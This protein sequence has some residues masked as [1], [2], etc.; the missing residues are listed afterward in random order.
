MTYFIQEIQTLKHKFEKK[1]LDKAQVFF[2]LLKYTFTKRP[3]QT[4]I[5]KWST[6]NYILNKVYNFNMQRYPSCYY[7]TTTGS[8]TVDGE[9]YETEHTERLLKK[10]GTKFLFQVC[11][12][13]TIS[14]V[15]YTDCSYIYKDANFIS[16]CQILDDD[17][18]EYFI[19][20]IQQQSHV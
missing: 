2:N 11:D 5:Q 7:S 3:I 15:E 18:L 14:E 17:T 10:V 6:Y 9:T 12:T 13:Y 1:I 16:D 20:K 4:D 19:N 8:I